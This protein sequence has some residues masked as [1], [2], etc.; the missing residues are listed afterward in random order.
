[1]DESRPKVIIL[2][3]GMGTRLRPI[4]DHIPK[5]LVELHGKPLLQ[6]LIEYYISSGYRDFILCIGYL[7][8]KIR[9][10]CKQ[11]NF[12]ANIAFSDAGHDA[13]MLSR[14]H[15]AQDLIGDLAFVA[16]GD[17][18]IKVDLDAM[19]EEHISSGAKA[20]I[21]T[22]NVRSPFGIVT[23]NSSNWVTSFIEKPVHS[24]YVGHMLIEKSLLATLNHKQI[25]L[26]D[27]EGLI[28]LLSDLAEKQLLKHQIYNGP[29]ITFNTNHELLEAQI[30]FT[31]FFTH[32]E[33]FNCQ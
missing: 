28:A 29:A 9:D 33:D 4:T 22:A 14:L 21:T 8:A 18:L 26:P 27:G 1:M 17:T 31:N 3:G 16:Y 12:S 20:T 2:C 7:G 13:S 25:L 19:V 32:S 24:Y 11:R 30:D 15:F 6:H 10:F 23:S 5:A